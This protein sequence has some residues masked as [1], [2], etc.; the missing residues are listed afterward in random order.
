VTLVPHP[1]RAPE[2]NP[3]E[4]AQLYLKERYVSHRLLDDY[5][6]VVKATWD[7][8]RRLIGEDGRLT[9]LTSCP[10]IEDHVMNQFARYEMFCVSSNTPTSFPLYMT[11]VR[12]CGV[13]RRA[14]ALIGTP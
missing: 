10:W 1:P 11:F 7:A 4:R 9:S 12:N 13:R 3:A 6:A 2:L 14:L 8:W 5:G